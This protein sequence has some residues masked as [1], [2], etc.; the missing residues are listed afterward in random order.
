MTA[1]VGEILALADE[2][3]AVAADAGR[4]IMAVYAAMEQG[5]VAAGAVTHKADDSPLTAADR[6]AHALIAGRLA[7]LTPAVPLVSEEDAALQRHR[8]SPGTFWLVDPLDGTREFLARNGEFTVNIALVHDGRPRWGVVLAP[9]L[10]MR[11]WGGPA[12]GAWRSE[13]SAR[14]PMRVATP[15]AG[16]AGRWRVL[17]SR[18]HL[19]AA[20]TAAIARLGAHELVQAGSSLKFCRIAEGRADLYLRLGPTCEW[21]T[22]AGQAVLEG[23]GG[24]VLDLQGQPLHYGKPDV[25]NPHFVA[26]SSPEVAGLVKMS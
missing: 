18:S 16:P 6:A 25:L 23:A 7:A 8:R 2:V 15:G 1:V 19:D 26:A 11:Y 21:D 10:G 22:A 12:L 17:A 24:V 3:V 9:A 20:T 14:V 13:V 5:G 4:A